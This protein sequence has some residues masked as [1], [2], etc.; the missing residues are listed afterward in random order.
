MT[1]VFSA[2]NHCW[3][4]TEIARLAIMP[5]PRGGEWLS[6]DI[7]FLK[8]SGVQAMVSADGKRSRG[9]AFIAGGNLLCS[10]W[11]ETI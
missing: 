8:R 9:I 1:G 5:R 3:I 2:M 11:I 7:G 10:A 4:K 6:D